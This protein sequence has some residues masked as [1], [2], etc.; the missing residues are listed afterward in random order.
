MPLDNPVLLIENW[1]DKY[2]SLG[3]PQTPAAPDVCSER[4]GLWRN[5]SVTGQYVKDILKSFGLV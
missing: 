4:C 5:H 3:K 2:D 1:I